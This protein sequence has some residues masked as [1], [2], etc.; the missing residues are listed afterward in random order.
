[1]STSSAMTDSGN[2]RRRNMRNLRM[3]ATYATMIVVAL[4]ILFPFYW[5]VTVSLKLPKEIYRTPSLVLQNPTF[6]NYRELIVERDF[7]INIR[8]SL[9]VSLSVTAVS[10]LISSFA[11]YSIVRFR[12]RWKGLIGK[13]ILFGYLM[14]TSL[15][16]IPLAVIVARLQLGDSLLGLV[17]VYLTFSIPLSTWLLGSYFRSV[18][19]ELE[20]QAMVDGTTRIG[21]LFR[22]LLPL[23]LPGLAAVSIFTLTMAWN[24]LLLALIFI[25]TDSKR[26]VPLGLQYMITGD[27]FLWGPIMAGAVVSS[28]PV[29]LLYFVAQK[30]MVSGLTIGSVKG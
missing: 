10:M 15:L 26:T 13:L 20:E 18:P 5:M 22:I 24:E 6:D 16:F 1:M 19:P 21:A 25:T 17:I 29:I 27:V 30:F 23:S 9:I 4:I 7:L 28:I 11:A 12:Y 8:N 3:F 2:N 14:P